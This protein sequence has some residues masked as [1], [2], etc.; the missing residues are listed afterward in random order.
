MEYGLDANPLRAARAYALFSIASHDAIIAVFDAKYA[1]WYIRPSQH[2][3]TITTLFPI[4]GTRAIPPLTRS[5][6]GDMP[7]C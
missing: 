2:D 5:T 6:M 7:R 1:Y 3:P 4:R